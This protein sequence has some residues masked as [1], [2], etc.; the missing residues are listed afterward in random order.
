MRR[1]AL[2]LSLLALASPVL[3]DVP[4]N[5][6]G[7]TQP[8]HQAS[9]PAMPFE[10][11]VVPPPMRP[12]EAPAS[13]LVRHTREDMTKLGKLDRN[14]S[15]ACQLGVFR[16]LKPSKMIA[17]SKDATLGVAFGHGL[18]LVDPKK[19]ADPSKVYYFYHGSTT[20]CLV[21]VEDNWNQAYARSR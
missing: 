1:F 7:R 3:A 8:L 20:L 17:V 6:I 14:L 2:A 5:A 12:D 10:Q 9:K 15:Q 13:I 4:R 11:A 21:R 19:L 16:E 18:G